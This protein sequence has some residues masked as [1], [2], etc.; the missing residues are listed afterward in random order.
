M[1]ISYLPGNTFMTNEP[2]PINK[3]AD[4]VLLVGNTRV[5]L[6]TVVSA[7]C[8]GVTAEGIAEQYPSLQLF[9]IYSVIAYYL[10]HQ[11]EVNAY[12][13]QRRAQAESVRREN[14][15]RFNPVGV[16]ARL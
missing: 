15:G 4:G 5:T 16:R 2:I 13:Q 8:E 6:D 3:T 9:E 14:E 1:E 12:L 11:A 7:F 10:R